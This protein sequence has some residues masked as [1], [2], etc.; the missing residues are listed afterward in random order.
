MFQP[1]V[2][3]TFVSQKSC[4]YF[5]AK[6]HENLC[7][8]CLPAQAR[9]GAPSRVLASTPEP[10]PLSSEYGT[11][12]TVKALASRHKSLKRSKLFP[13][14]SAADRRATARRRDASCPNL[15]LTVSCVPY[16]LDSG[17][18]KHRTGARRI[19]S[20]AQPHGEGRGALG[21]RDARSA[22]SQF[23]T[24]KTARARF[25]HWLEPFFRLITF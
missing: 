4:F 7:R 14:R 21:G 6:S 18:C 17:P 16:S 8:C 23:G 10:L 13:F 24:D 19:A 22:P 1:K 15:A 3:R 2:M 5:S 25:W 20:A 12:K 11:Y 9:D